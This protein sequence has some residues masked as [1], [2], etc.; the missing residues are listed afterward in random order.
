MAPDIDACPRGS[1]ISSVRRSSLL[2]R[3]HCR[4]SAIVAPG[5]TPTPPVITRVGIPSVWQSTA[6][7]TRLDR[8]RSAYR[9]VEAVGDGLLGGRA[10]VGLLLGQQRLA[11]RAAP[12]AGAPDQV[13]RQLDRLDELGLGVP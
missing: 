10:H 6:C 3:N 8:T 4:R 9:S 13:H 12:A 11:R 5:S 1:Y 2:S 7:G